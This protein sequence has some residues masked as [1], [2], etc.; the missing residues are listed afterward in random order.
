MMSVDAITDK[1]IQ[2]KKK[3]KWK[4]GR[5]STNK[6]KGLCPHSLALHTGVLNQMIDNN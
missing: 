3:V 5:K 1:Q 2:Q 4:E 6:E